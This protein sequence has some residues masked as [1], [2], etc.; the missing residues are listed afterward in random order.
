MDYGETYAPVGKLTMF[1]LLTSIAAR[2]KCNI[3]HLVVV[4]AFLNPD[5]ND[6]TLLMQ[7]AERWPES[8]MDN[9]PEEEHSG[10][11]VVRLQT[12]LDGLK[13]AP[14]LWYWHIIANLL[15]L[16]FFQSEADPNLYI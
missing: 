5:I 4:T 3:D 16:D 10:V 1:Q 11:R 12:A 6:D 7:L 14:H 15:S 2:N 9:C 8:L 13:Q